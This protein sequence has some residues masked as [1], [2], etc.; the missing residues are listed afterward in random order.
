[1]VN[2]WFRH[3]RRSRRL[4]VLAG[5]VLCAAGCAPLF[6]PRSIEVPQE[7]LA[8]WAIGRFPYSARLLD[9]ID[10]GVAAPRLRLLPEANRI[11]LD[12]DVTLGEPVLRLVYRGA[13]T[14][15]AGL[16]F[17]VADNTV[18]LTNVQIE[19]LRIDGLPAG[20]QRQVERAGARLAEQLLSDRAVY[21]LRPQDVDAMRTYHQHPGELRVTASGLLITFV[22]DAPR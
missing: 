4:F 18:R 11:A 21:T 6:A 17:E 7:R 5:A 2:S 16:R 10:L 9:V 22:P 12:V 14:L 15:A 3:R 1:M 20:L 8:Q 13:V 19:Q